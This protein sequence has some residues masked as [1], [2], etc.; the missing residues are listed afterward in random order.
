M[1]DEPIRRYLRQY[2]SN[3][4]D[5][6][7]CD[8]Q[9]IAIN[10]HSFKSGSKLKLEPNLQ[11]R[12]GTVSFPL[13]D[14]NNRY[15]CATCKH[16]TLQSTNTL[17]IQTNSGKE[18]PATVFYNS[19]D[20]DFSLVKLKN[21]GIFCSHGIRTDNNEFRS[22]EILHNDMTPLDDSIVYKWGATTGITLGK[23]KGLL[24]S[25]KGK[26]GSYDIG[27]FIIDGQS[28]P[29]SREGDSGSLVCIKPDSVI[30]TKHMASF[31]LIGEIDKYAGNDFKNIHACYSVSVPLSE[32]K[33]TKLCKKINPCFSY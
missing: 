8:Y 9:E 11:G 21:Q 7:I 4:S 33:N 17:Y 23:Y 27:T 15:Y 6:K 32:M 1:N 25:R 19:D 29:F 3:I 12:Y 31:I 14:A 20:C 2:I 30:Y 5:V 18:L 22:G 16:V 24:C 13:N 10:E 26:T 28:E